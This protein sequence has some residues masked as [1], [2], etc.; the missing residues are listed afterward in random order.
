M[1]TSSIETNS[2]NL[3]CLKLEKQEVFVGTYSGQRPSACF[4]Q[5]LGFL[6]VEGKEKMTYRIFF[7]RQRGVLTRYVN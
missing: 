6:E 7:I 2:A 1:V 3:I 4:Q 5:A